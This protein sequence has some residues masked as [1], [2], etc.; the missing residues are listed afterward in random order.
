M[1]DQVSSV[2]RSQTN[3]STTVN[4]RTQAQQILADTSGK[5]A[6]FDKLGQIEARLDAIARTNPEL[7]A[8]V[9]AEI[10]ASPR[11]TTVEKAQLRS[12]ESGTTVDL[13]GRT[14]NRFAPGGMAWDPWID[15][16]RTRNSAEYQALSRLAGST[17]NA[18]IK[19]VMRELHDR[20]ISAAQLETE[21]AAAAGPDGTQLTLDLVQMALDLTG[22]VDPTPISD[23][24]NAVISLGRSVSS[25]FS[26]EWSAAGGHLVNGAISV[27][28]FI[29]ALGDLAK[30]GKIGK[31]AQTV[32]D[33]ISMISRNPALAEKLLPTL[34]EIRDLVNQIPQ[35]ALDAL[36]ASAR[37]SLQRMKGQLDELF[38]RAGTRADEAVGA[39][40][41]STARVGSNSA[42]WTLDASGRPTRVSATLS[43]I[44]PTR[45]R[46]TDELAAQD[47]VRELGIDGDD[48]GH[49]IGHRFMGDQ[50]ERN[51]FPQ[52]F[53]FN[54]SAYKKME[55]EWEAWVQHGGTVRVNVELI[56]G[57]AGRPDRVAV[58]YEVLD[59]AG[60][61][62]F[63]RDTRFTNGA[64]Q[65][66]QR[67]SA[68]E[69]SRM[70]R[71]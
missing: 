54:R 28:G 64:D 69:I 34:R 5:P 8:Q 71:R 20:G 1:V 24:S 47:R 31:W 40:A 61:S 19:E 2:P 68:T 13:D 12:N 37:E 10:M 33:A 62:I 7:A 29:P 22:I 6:T 45:A 66:F 26:G 30:A 42:E 48:A 60:T 9:R 50:G 14:T 16:N 3:T 67:M 51:M 25:L 32:S 65:T 38:G 21:R 17:E 36:P 53:N 11:L 57:T 63:Q 70:M 18:P 35:S 49:V 27:V 4:P 58:S 15:S 39:A 55:N 23:G 44:Q 41:T 56:G 43:E 46:S 59:Q 52:N